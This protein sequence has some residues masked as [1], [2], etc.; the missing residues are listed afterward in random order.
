MNRRDVETNEGLK[1]RFLKNATIA[2]FSFLF[3]CSAGSGAFADPLTA[4]NFARSESRKL[5][6]DQVDIG[7]CAGMVCEF[8]RRE[9]PQ[10]YDK[11]CK[12]LEQDTAWDALA[13]MSPGLNGTIAG[14]SFKLWSFQLYNIRDNPVRIKLLLDNVCKPALIMFVK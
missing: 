9:S 4:D 6:F 14:H 7:T 3:A 10:S 13:K 2:A 8:E 11:N 12:W 5:G 1:R